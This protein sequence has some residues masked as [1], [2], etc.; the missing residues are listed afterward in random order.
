[1]SRVLSVFS[2]GMMTMLYGGC[3]R[4]KGALDVTA[5]LDGKAT[6]DACVHVT[7]NFDARAPAFI[8]DYKSG[9]D[10]VAT[11]SRLEMKY[12]FSAIHVYTAL[13]G[14][15]AQLTNAAL[16]GV[17]CEPVVAAISHDGIAT[18]ATA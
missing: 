18:F 11:T 16:S 13:P 14:F 7:G 12:G 17:R 6:L 15:A 2:L 1:M 8:V 10:P 4:T 5:P 3:Q 9:V